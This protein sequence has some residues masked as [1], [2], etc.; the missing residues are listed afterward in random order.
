MS[1]FASS[2]PIAVL[3]LDDNPDELELMRLAAKRCRAPFVVISASTIAAAK[4]RLEEARAQRGSASLQML[5][6]DYELKEEVGTDL[7]RWVRNNPALAALPVILLTD[8][9]DDCMQLAYAA[10]ADH[11]LSKPIL[12]ERLSVM[13]EC[14]SRCVA[15]SPPCFASLAHLEEHRPPLLG[16]AHAA[17]PARPSRPAI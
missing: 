7:I 12:L 3:H 2:L 6:L 10:G 8:G 13:V 4:Q 11:C 17:Q 1:E 9:D 5:L 16:G 14:L 15:S